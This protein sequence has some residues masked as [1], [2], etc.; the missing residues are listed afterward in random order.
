MLGLVAE[1]LRVIRYRRR[2]HAL[3]AAAQ[4]AADNATADLDRRIRDQNRQ[5]KPG[6]SPRTARPFPPHAVS[7][8]G[9][10]P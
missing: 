9:A 4:A 5:R 7:L 6:A 10:R 8:P 3:A 2:W 1:F